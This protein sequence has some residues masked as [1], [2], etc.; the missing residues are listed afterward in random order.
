MKL[1]H[2]VAAML[3]ALTILA[4]FASRHV[5][6][7]PLESAPS[8]EPH[9]EAH[10]T[11]ST[12]KEDST[13]R[14]RISVVAEGAAETSSGTSITTAT[15]KVRVVTAIDHRP[16][17]GVRVAALPQP[18]PHDGFA[19]TRNDSDHGTMDRP[20][21][22]GDDG[23][24][25]L[26]LPTNRCFELSLGADDAATD[27]SAH[28]ISALKPGE[29]RDLEFEV[30]TGEDQLFFGRVID[31]E[32]RAPLS[33]KIDVDAVGTPKYSKSFQ[34]DEEG[35][36]SVLVPS[37][38]HP[39]LSVVVAGYGPAFV[40]PDRLH[41]SSEHA[42]LIEL[43]RAATLRMHMIDA[44]DVALADLPV[45][46]RAPT[47][48]LAHPEG[49]TWSDLNDGE[50]WTRVGTTDARG[51]SEFSGVPADVPLTVSATRALD[52]AFDSPTP[53][54]LKPGEVREVT[55]RIPARAML[56]GRITDRSGEPVT[57][58]VVWLSASKSTFNFDGSSD[59]YLRTTTTDD[60]GRFK[61]DTVAPRS[62]FVGPANVRRRSDPPDS[63][64]VAPSAQQI[65]IHEGELRD[66]VEL[67]V[68]RGLYI[69]G[70]LLEP[71]G[72]PAEDVWA[73]AQQESLDVYRYA[74]GVKGGEFAIGP[75]ERGTYD[76]SARGSTR[77]ATSEH[78]QCEA[79]AL[80]VVLH[81]KM[82]CV[83]EG[84]VLDGET[85][86]PVKVGGVEFNLSKRPGFPRGGTTTAADGTF[87]LFGLDPDTYELVVHDTRG[88]F[89]LV[90]RLALA[91]GETKSD[92]KLRL[93][94][95]ARVR[96][97]FVHAADAELTIFAEGAV[98]ASNEIASGTV[99]EFEVPT[100]RLTLSI[101]LVGRDGP[102]DKSCD[103]AAGET[104]DLEFGD[105]WR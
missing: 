50:F 5:T 86:Q 41:D 94:S 58:C 52:I 40:S 10:S 8:I 16:I 77:F 38:R 81:L 33:G 55:L 23:R 104:K 93:E 68:D 18:L 54:Q 34:T 29:V 76:V 47:Y 59:P 32:T 31:R 72:S 51:A 102:L 62:W 73:C 14:E 63:G 48:L 69:R 43:A 2:F 4:M 105:D 61:F 27:H 35:R 46:V 71:D 66:D 75:L 70:R 103:F 19:M 12:P 101:Q 64:L 26:T 92:V 36:F 7:S 82:A 91:E 79:G 83:I 42:F 30:L 98:I 56:C 78:L 44:T 97:H 49:E 37:W 53:I 11:A 45:R 21:I 57:H 17:A 67:S 60:D 85:G 20:P 1:R 96:V 80:D 74:D 87:V 99:R 28:D 65:E 95:G 24:V 84:A 15:V 6:T 13:A 90:H 88:R 22:T 39:R 100:G 89:A 9:L 3:I 25:E